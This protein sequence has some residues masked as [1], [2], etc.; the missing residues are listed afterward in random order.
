MKRRAANSISL[1]SFLLALTLG[2]SV[3]AQ[4][5]APQF[6]VPKL[7]QP[8]GPFG[9]GRIG[10][11][12]IDR[13][14]GAD[15]A[16][17]RGAH[18]E[19]MVY[20]WYPTEAGNKEVKGVLFPGAKQI[21]SAPDFSASL[22]E[23]VF[24]GN[25]PLV[26]SGAITSHAQENA[27]IA[28]NPRIFPVVLF[29]PAA[30]GSSFQYSSAIEDFVSHGYVVASIEHTS[31]VFGVI[32]LDG[33]IHI[34][35]ATRIPKQ[36]V[37]LPDATRE[38][39]EAKLQAWSRHC[40]DVRAADASFVLDKLIELNKG[41]FGSSQFSQ[42]LDVA[43]VAAVGHSRGG[44][45]SI[46][47]CRRDER[48]SACVNEDGNN[49]GQGLDYPGA[50]TPKQPIMYL[51]ISPVLKPGFTQDDWIV[52]K[53]LNLTPEQW[54]QQWHETVN[55]EF[56]TFPAGGYF[57]QLTRP[58]LEHYSFSDEVI[59]RTAKVGANEREKIALDDLSFTENLTRAFLDEVLKNR[60]QTILRDGSE[61]AVKHFG[62][63]S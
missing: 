2:A 7:P 18:A 12:W 15:M 54:I 61:I 5:E 22:K 50:L 56:R 59:L 9:V 1:W 44:W 39:Y 46:I 45:S 31:E 8:S 63:G 47:T 24:G 29:S 14:R 37:P 19:L 27:P 33:T 23:K 49:R 28:K 35:S 10:F 11:D 55:K 3:N 17:D 57:V 40:V 48:I 41:A 34:Y 53:Q 6:N 4:K 43:H 32:F 58:G 30:S 38:E 16:E 62:P 51:E 26:V 21:D 60:Q 42:R 25:W 36:S 13:N 20:V 52:L